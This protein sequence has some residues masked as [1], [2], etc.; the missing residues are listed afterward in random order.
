M[1]RSVSSTSALVTWLTGILLV[2]IARTLA[3]VA[4]VGGEADDAR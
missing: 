3:A 4:R 1:R 2:D